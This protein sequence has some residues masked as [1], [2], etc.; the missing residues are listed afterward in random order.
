MNKFIKIEDPMGN[1][2]LNADKVVAVMEDV[3]GKYGCLIIVEG[4]S[5]LITLRT[6][7]EQIIKLFA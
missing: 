1:Y 3:E 6:P 7:Y 4:I 5:E 2:L